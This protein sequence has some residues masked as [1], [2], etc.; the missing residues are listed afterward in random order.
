MI[1]ALRSASRPKPTCPR[2]GGMLALAAILV[3]VSSCRSGGGDTGVY[4][5][6][7]GRELTRRLY[8]GA[9]D[10]LP[11]NIVLD[12]G[13]D[14]DT[15]LARW[16]PGGRR[17]SLGREWPGGPA[18][19]VEGLQA[20]ATFLA[21]LEAVYGRE[22]EMVDEGVY[23]C[24]Y[25]LCELPRS[26][27]YNRIARFSGYTGN[28]LTIAWLWAGDSLV[29]GWIIPSRRT[30]PSD[31]ETYHPH[32]TLRLPF[33]GEW[34]VLWGGPKPHENYH[35]AVPPL[36]FA[37]DFVVDS[38]GSLHRSDG[39]NNADYYCYGRPI[40]APAGGRVAMAL[41][42]FA[43]NVPGTSRVRYRGPG[44]VVSIDHGNGEFSILAHLRRGSVRVAADQRIEAGDTVG[45][46]GNNGESVVPHLHYQLQ[47]DSRPGSRPVPAPF[48]DFLA[49]GE[50]VVRGIP[51]RGQR[52]VHAASGGR[53]D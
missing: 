2:V 9:F 41:D 45:A 49:E 24:Y 8:A 28:T 50:R 31:L 16:F 17:D 36:R 6:E 39:R 53:R 1:V 14:G 25:P 46:C 10:S 27:E 48:S 20:G 12:L 51:T 22:V 23:R 7:R 47:L 11:R 30:V 26:V 43:E 37:Y 29:G 19:T 38:A 32:T 3:T 42:S 18:H 13:G 40:L 34:T 52:L 5:V 4:P 33:D 15:V 44:N 35:V 21:R